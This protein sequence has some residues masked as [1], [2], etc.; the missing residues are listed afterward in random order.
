MQVGAVGEVVKS[1]LV[2]I[3][4]SGLHMQRLDYLWPPVE[5]RPEIDAAA[6]RQRRSSML[7][8]TC[9][10]VSITIR[11]GSG[12]EDFLRHVVSEV[13]EVFIEHGGQLAGLGIVVSTI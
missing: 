10:R 1:R 4:V 9:H 3:L 5:L 8:S 7:L 6:K 12:I 13:F 11:F 2:I